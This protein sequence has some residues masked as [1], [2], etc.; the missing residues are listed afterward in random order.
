MTE[1]LYNRQFVCFFHFTNWGHISFGLHLHLPSPNLEI[2]IPFGFFRI[3][4]QGTYRRE[5]IRRWENGTFGKDY[6][7]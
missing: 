3:G 1:R 4:F 7:P 5:L 6:I 2:H